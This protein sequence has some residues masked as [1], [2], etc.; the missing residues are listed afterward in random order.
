MLR[1][2]FLIFELLS[3]A[4][5]AAAVFLG[6]SFWPF[7][8]LSFFWTLAIAFAI[9]LLLVSA[10]LP[11]PGVKVLAI[12]AIAIACVPVTLMPK[13]PAA[14][15]DHTLRLITANLFIGNADPR[16]FV[17]FLIREQPDIV[18]TQ[19]TPVIFEDAIRNSGLFPFESSRDMRATDDKKVFSRFPIR[20]EVQL[21]DTAGA[22]YLERH[23]MR[24]VLDTPSGPLVL[25]AV[26]PDSPRSVA[27]WKQ[28]NL[29]LETLTHYV[30]QE[31]KMLPVIV[32]GDWNTPP[33][34]GY[35]RDFFERTG[36]RYMQ[37]HGWPA[38][39]R[40]LTRFQSFMTFGAAI[41][42]VALSP[43]I[44]MADWQVGPKFGSN[45]LPVIIDF[46]LPHGSALAE[47]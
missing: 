23:P 9:V 34:S 33:W 11:G 35:F 19:E 45:H 38:T 44:T 6:R 4:G 25:Y 5:L 39:T 36:F 31:P 2:M 1:T 17:A 30:S 24:L 15:R 22:P 21:S 37:G 3:I 47:R 26:H 14:A 32:A 43:N 12:I 46:G 27:R 7:D 13:A 10:L 40:F 28:R 20:D 41:D 42:H 8:L 16:E 29:Y 18:V